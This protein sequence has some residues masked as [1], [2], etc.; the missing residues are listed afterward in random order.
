MITTHKPDRDPITQYPHE[1][2]VE[3]FWNLGLTILFVSL[4]GFVFV[5]IAVAVMR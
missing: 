4:T 3:K 2:I 1:I 5:G